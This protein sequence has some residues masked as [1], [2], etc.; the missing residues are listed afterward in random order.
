MVPGK[1]GPGGVWEGDR[2]HVAAAQGPR[3]P[4]QGHP[5]WAVSRTG[6]SFAFDRPW[7]CPVPTRLPSPHS[8]RVTGVYELSLCHVADAG[9]P[10]RRLGGGALG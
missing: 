1:R 9:S 6:A 3:G 5:A 8:N 2:P 7:P 4:A 10:G